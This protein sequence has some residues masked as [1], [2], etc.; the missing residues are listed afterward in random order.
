MSKCNLNTCSERI[1]SQCV[2]FTC[3][4]TSSYISLPDCNATLCDYLAV[5]ERLITELKDADGILASRLSTHNCGFTPIVDLIDTKDPI[6][7]K[8]KTSDAVIALLDVICE[9]KAQLDNI[10]D[11]PLPAE[12]L[13]DPLLETCLGET[14]CTTVVP[15]TLKELLIAMMHHYCGCCP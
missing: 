12:I 10:W 8:V 6:Y 3:D 13:N 11:L 9:L 14:D 2:L 5:T 15:R 4:V 1:P 7:L